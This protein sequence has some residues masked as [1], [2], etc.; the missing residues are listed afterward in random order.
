MARS[1]SVRKRK[2]PP[3][4]ATAFSIG[5]RKRGNDGKMWQ[6]IASGKSKRWIR[7]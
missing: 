5:T 2:G 6:V 1:T 4:S 3:V 7:S